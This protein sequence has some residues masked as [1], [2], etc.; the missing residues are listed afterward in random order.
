MRDK[1]I[2]ERLKFY[3]RLLREK[4]VDLNQLNGTPE[5]GRAENHDTGSHS[6]S[7]NVWQ[8]PTQSTIFKAQLRYAQ[9]GTE[10]VDK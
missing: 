3:E 2:D 9:G 10:L 4:G 6:V 8:L 1:L 5:A 7:E